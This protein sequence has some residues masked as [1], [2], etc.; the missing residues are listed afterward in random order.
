M[1]SPWRDHPIRLFRAADSPVIS[2]N[3]LDRAH[4]P[5]TQEVFFDL[6]VA[7]R[8]G[9]AEVAGD[10][11]LVTFGGDSLPGADPLFALH[12]R[13]AG[14]AVVYRQPDTGVPSVTAPGRTH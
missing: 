7:Q 4:R 5:P 2:N 1:Q 8:R 10:T 6:W 13:F 9:H 12:G 11:L 3:A 14:E